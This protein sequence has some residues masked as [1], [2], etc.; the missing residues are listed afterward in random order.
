MNLKIEELNEVKY[1]EYRLQLEPEDEALLL[2]IGRS[3][4]VNDKEKCLDYAIQK[5][6]EWYI[7]GDKETTKDESYKG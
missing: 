1:K 5:L 7:F 6:I 2:E 3:N 4:I